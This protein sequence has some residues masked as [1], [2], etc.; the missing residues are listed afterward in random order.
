MN[1]T[2]DGQ[3]RKIKAD[4]ELTPSINTINAGKYN[5]PEA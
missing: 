4:Y 5:F 1:R 3:F 2:L